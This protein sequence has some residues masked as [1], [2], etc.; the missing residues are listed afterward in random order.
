MAK[1]NIPEGTDPEEVRRALEL[2]TIYPDPPKN[3]TPY[4]VYG[5]GEG[6]IDIGTL[7]AELER[8]HKEVAELWSPLRWYLNRK[9][10]RII[11]KLDEAR[12]AAIRRYFDS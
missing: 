8:L 1:I 2:I 12:D 10:N 5:S 9:L 11:T 4:D 7:G 3:V 6:A